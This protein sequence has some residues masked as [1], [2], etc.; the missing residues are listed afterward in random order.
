MRRNRKPEGSL[1]DKFDFY[2]LTFVFIEKTPAN[3]APYLR[4]ADASRFSDDEP[5]N[6]LLQTKK[7]IT[8]R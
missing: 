5:E 7:P 1:S 3:S 2:K 8:F 6:I 4:V